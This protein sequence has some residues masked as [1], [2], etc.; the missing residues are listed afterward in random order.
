MA[1]SRRVEELRS[2]L[3]GWKGYFGY[4]ETPSTLQ[5]LDEWV[6]RRLRC[7]LWKQWTTSKRR[8]RELT[9]RGASRNLA[10]QT[11][12]SPHGAWR[13]SCSPALNIALPIRFFEE[14]GLPSL[15]KRTD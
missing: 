12:G 6:R 2:Y 8:F 9:Q 10:A 11:V 15:S 1:F 5:R 7:L 14:Q 4:C 3:T 13:L